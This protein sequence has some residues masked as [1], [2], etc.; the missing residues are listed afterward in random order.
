[1][2]GSGS[3][4]GVGDDWTNIDIVDFGNNIV[5]DLSKYPWPFDD[6]TFDYIEAV[7]ILE[8][9]L[10]AVSFINEMIRIGKQGCKFKIQVPNAKYPEAVWTD[11]EH[12]RGFTSRSFDYWHPGTNLFK[13]YGES[14]NQRTFFINDLIVK[15]LNYNLVFIFTK[16]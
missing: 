13:R 9:I 7:D 10:D 6:N 11:P 2:V 4:P 1:M 8:H 16:R 5:H 12:I 3:A 15:E 14:K